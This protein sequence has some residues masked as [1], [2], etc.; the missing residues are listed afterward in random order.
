M[1]VYSL[2]YL[3]GRGIRDLI[4]KAARTGPPKQHEYNTKG[5]GAPYVNAVL[6]AFFLIIL[7]G[8]FLIT[9]LTTGLGIARLLAAHRAGLALSCRA[10][11]LV[12]ARLASAL[13]G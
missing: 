9:G 8:F 1:R 12:G 4:K 10:T 3:V 5:H 7:L 13:L 2:A 11:L 6:P